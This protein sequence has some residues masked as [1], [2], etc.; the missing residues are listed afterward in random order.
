MTNRAAILLAFC[1]AS[2]QAQDA[3]VEKQAAALI[4]AHTTCTIAYARPR[5]NWQAAPG[6]LAD[7]ALATCA[8]EQGDIMSAAQKEGMSLREAQDFVAVLMKQSR[9][10]LIKYILESRNP[11]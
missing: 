5:M 1:A 10:T 2:G 4:N 8:N 9:I 3:D 7:A 6:D 11:G